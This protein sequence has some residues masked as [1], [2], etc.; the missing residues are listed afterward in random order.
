MKPGRGSSDIEL[1]LKVSGEIEGPFV[2]LL[3]NAGP[4]W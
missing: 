1:G 2:D 4:D 3:V